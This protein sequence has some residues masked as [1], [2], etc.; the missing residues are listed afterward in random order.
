[1]S[2]YILRAGILQIMVI[3]MTLCRLVCGYTFKKKMLPTSSR[4]KHYTSNFTI[5]DG[6]CAKVCFLSPFCGSDLPS[7]FQLTSIINTDFHPNDFSVNPRPH[8][9]IQKIQV[10]Y[11]SKMLLASSCR[12]TQCQTPEGHSLLALVH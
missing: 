10:S 6:P 8:L 2:F 1:M 7:F 11:F 5:R 9:S 12:A 4:L 3:V